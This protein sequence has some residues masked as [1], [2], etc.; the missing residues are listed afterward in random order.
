MERM[1]F[2]LSQFTVKNYRSIKNEITLDMQATSNS[3]HPEHVF[4]LEKGKF[5]EKYLPLS[6][7]Y[8]PNGAGKSNII[9]AFGAMLNKIVSPMKTIFRDDYNERTHIKVTPFKLA[10]DTL[11]NPTEF[12]VYFTTSD[13]E[14]RYVLHVRREDVVFES[15]DRKKFSTNRISRLFV[16]KDVEIKL[17]NEFSK[18]KITKDISS[19]LPL[20]SYLGITYNTNIIVNDVISWLSYNVGVLNFGNPIRE[21]TIKI[22]Q[23]KERKV[24]FLNL[25]QNLDIDIVDFRMEEVDGRKDLYTK[26]IVDGFE[27]E[28]TLQE[29]SQGTAKLFSLLYYIITGLEEGRVLMVDELDAKLHP[30]ILEYIIQLF[31]NPKINK[32]G[33]QLIFTS[34]DL[35]TMNSTVFRRDEIWFVAKGNDQGSVLY[36]LAEFKQD[37]KSIRK[38]A[39]FDKDY[40]LGKYGADPYLVRMLEWEDING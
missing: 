21:R 16:R 17:F 36:S 30:K 13:S 25:L 38:D 29:E 9:E 2:M 15:L 14:Y 37:G 24:Q 1:M 23:S 7:I 34:H 31:S 28:L 39:S 12:E 32:N 4:K 33:A 19:N 10:K 11:N 6:V 35:Y 8:G 3:E 22:P 20:L 40:V 27:T 5:N 18:F 26:H